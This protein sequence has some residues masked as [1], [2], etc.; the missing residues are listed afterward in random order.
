MDV[1]GRLQSPID[2]KA[3]MQIFIKDESKVYKDRSLDNIKFEPL[4]SSASKKREWD[5]H[6][7]A[8]LTAIERQAE[9]VIGK[10]WQLALD[11]IG[12]LQDVVLWLHRNHQG[13]PLL[14]R[15]IGKLLM[16]KQ[17]QSNPLYGANFCSYAEWCYRRGDPVSGRVLVAMMSIRLRVDR[18]RGKT[19]NIMPVSYTHLTLPTTK[20]V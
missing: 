5:L 2:H 17:N 1:W 7:I 4:P 14:D 11:P 16:T 18:Q 3:I 15:F 9:S 12:S 8:Q 13:L 10:W 19:L 20:Q 6:S